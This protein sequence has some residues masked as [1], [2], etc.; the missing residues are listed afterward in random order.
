MSCSTSTSTPSRISATRPGSPTACR[1][2]SLASLLIVYIACGA[3]YP[4]IAVL[5]RSV[6]PLLGMAGLAALVIGSVS[7]W[8]LQ[9]ASR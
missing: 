1:R 3:T 6:P 8:V 2:E 5:V 7:L 4:A 9:A